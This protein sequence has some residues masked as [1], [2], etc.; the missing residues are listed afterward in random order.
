LDVPKAQLPTADEAWVEYRATPVYGLA[1]WLATLS[2]DSYQSYEIS[3]T[4]SDRF[5]AAFVE[6]DTLSALSA[7]GA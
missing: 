6:L 3:R 2:T 1:I 5:A 7:I 4:L